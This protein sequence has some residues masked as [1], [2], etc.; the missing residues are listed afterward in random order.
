MSNLRKP[1]NE[2]FAGFYSNPTLVGLRD[3]L[4]N[5]YGEF[6]NIDFKV[7]WPALSK[8][9]RHI[10][11]FANSGGGCIVIG[12]T[13]KEDN[14][15]ESIGLSILIEK[16]EIFNGVKKYIP[17][18]LLE[19][20][21]IVNFKYEASE[22]PRL[23]GMSFQVL[24]ISTD[25]GSLPYISQ[26]EGD[27]IRNNAIYVRRGPATEEANYDELQRVINIRIET[28]YS[29]QTEMDT[30]THLEQ[31]KLLYGQIEK[32]HVR[33][34]GGIY[35]ILNSMVN[36]PSLSG[37]QENVP[38]PSYPEEDYEKFI[39]RMIEKKKKRIEMELDVISLK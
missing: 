30:R 26:F 39:V 36:M 29:S 1:I 12:V 23:K 20:I 4:K 37:K 5:N 2:D 10:L 34:T 33:I 15:L 13:E 9:A 31:L 27:G 17:S 38:N 11:G 21:D 28:G 19:D 16:T 8:L 6:P 25:K 7:E 3:I 22:Y 14:S 24:F 32:Y 35:Q 18:K